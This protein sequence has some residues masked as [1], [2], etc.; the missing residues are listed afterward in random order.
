[1]LTVVTYFW[2]DPTRDNRGYT[3]KDEYVRILKAMVKRNLTVPHRFV[4]VTDH[5]IEGVDTFP[6][7]F[8]KHVE[9]TV[10]LRLMQHNPEFGEK[11]GATRILSLDLDMVVVGSLDGL[12]SR[13]EDFVIWRNPNF[14]APKR[15]YFQ[16]SVQLFTPGS[17]PELW[18]DFDPSTTPLWVNWRFGGR[19][20]AWISER[21]GW[22]NTPIFTDA[23]GVYGL[24]RLAGQGI[25]DTLPENA[26]LVSTPGARAPWQKEIRNAFPWVKEHY[27]DGISPRNTLRRTKENAQ[28]DHAKERQEA[29]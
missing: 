22:K 26:C 1:M 16:S 8:T 19:E 28:N 10:F 3:F 6:L 18:A 9:G 24:G 17:R 14:P 11:L 4:C 13:P 21:L 2:N 7:D 29:R 23:D 27:H 5:E 12:V 25:Y 20:Q 15:A